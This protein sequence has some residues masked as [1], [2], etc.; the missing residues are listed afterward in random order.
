MQQLP[1]MVTMDL[2]LL[3]WAQWRSVMEHAF[4]LCLGKGKK[5]HL[6][7]SLQEAVTRSPPSL[8][9]V[10]VCRMSALCNKGPINPPWRH[11]KKRKT[12]FPNY[13]SKKKV[14]NKLSE[15]TVRSSCFCLCTGIPVDSGLWWTRGEQHLQIW[16]HLPEVWTGEWPY[17]SCHFTPVYLTH[18]IWSYTLFYLMHLS[19]YFL[20]STISVSLPLRRQRKS[21]LGT[22]RRRRLSRSFSVSWATTLNSTTLK[23]KSR[24]R[25][26]LNKRKETE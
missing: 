25:M 3:P 23:G 4:S 15:T 17:G 7:L 24:S 6:C 20:S 13:H 12:C 21:C 8:R 10:T 22:M 5:P 26:W 1:K 14:W 11:V 2:F 9:A 18:T 19:P 16:S